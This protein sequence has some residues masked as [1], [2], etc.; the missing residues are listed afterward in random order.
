LNQSIRNLNIESRL[1]EIGNNGAIDISHTAGRGIHPEPEI[2]PINEI[3]LKELILLIF[4]IVILMLFLL[5]L[6]PVF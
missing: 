2:A 5:Y 1:F 3:T 6:A 4:A